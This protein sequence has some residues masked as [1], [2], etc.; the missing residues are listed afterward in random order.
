MEKAK[1]L[2]NGE[3][4]ASIGAI[5]SEEEIVPGEANKIGEG[6]IGLAEGR[7]GSVVQ[8]K[9]GSDVE[10]GEGEEDDKVDEKVEEKKFFGLF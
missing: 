4:G 7:K 5:I 6:F 1:R 3:V 8:R 9:G 10:E 2:L